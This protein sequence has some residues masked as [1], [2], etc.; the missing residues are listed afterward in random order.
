MNTEIKC[1]YKGVPFDLQ[2]L[3]LRVSRFLIGSHIFGFTPIYIYIYF[4]LIL[5]VPPIPSVESNEAITL[6]SA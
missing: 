6:I 3:L 2:F 5:I 1:K 4:F